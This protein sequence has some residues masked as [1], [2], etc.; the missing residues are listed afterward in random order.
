MVS[1]SLASN[2]STSYRD[3]YEYLTNF[4]ID[5]HAGK[6]NTTALNTC[7][8]VHSLNPTEQTLDS[9]YENICK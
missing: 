2:M 4:F 9:M 6:D 5:W 1:W 3:V 7:R 8:D